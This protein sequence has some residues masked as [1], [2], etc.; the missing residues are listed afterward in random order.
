MCAAGEHSVA[1][2]S[3]LRILQSDLTHVEPWQIADLYITTA[4]LYWRKKQPVRSGMA[5][6]SALRT[7]P[8]VVGRPLK[9]LLRRAR[10]VDVKG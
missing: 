1:L 7:R 2:E 9:G 3:A 10:L 6:G 5:I 8:A 4:N